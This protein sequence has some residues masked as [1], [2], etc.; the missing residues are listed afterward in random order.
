M[1]TGFNPERF[2]EVMKELRA[3]YEAFAPAPLDLVSQFVYS[4]LLWEAGA[5]DAERVFK[6]ITA[7]IVDFNDLRIFLP[8]EI[9]SLL[10]TRYPRGPER[11]LR[12]RAALNELYQREHAVSFDRLKEAPKR[13][14]RQYVETLEG[15]PPF[16]S[17]RLTLLGFGGHACPLDERAL[18]CLIE[19]GVFEEST[20]LD[21]ATASLERHIKAAEGVETHILLMQR[22]EDGGGRGRGGGKKKTRKR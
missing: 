19:D 5:A 21:R 10:G 3:R 11:A 16:V 18:A 4:F 9:M 2:D 1:S 15:V 22:R 12:L 7:E 13:E 14:S 6:R 17:A 8:D 20:P